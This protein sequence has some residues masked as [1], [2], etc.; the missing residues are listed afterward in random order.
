MTDCFDT[1]YR[2]ILYGSVV[3]SQSSVPFSMTG[4]RG[5]LGQTFNSPPPQPHST[6]RNGTKALSRN[7]QKEKSIALSICLFWSMAAKSISL[8]GRVSS[9]PIAS[10]SIVPYACTSNAVTP[11]TMAT[12]ATYKVPKVENENNVYLS[13]YN[14]VVF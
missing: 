7:V 8:L 6:A 11:S 12:I 14:G 13:P 10:R 9:R 2:S 4:N 3:V 1:R 5:I